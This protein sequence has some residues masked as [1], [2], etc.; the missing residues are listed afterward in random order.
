MIVLGSTT[1]TNSN[2]IASTM[3]VSGKKSSSSTKR[4]WKSKLKEYFDAKMKGGDVCIRYDLKAEGNG[5]IATVF[6]PEIGYI[7]GDVCLN[8]QD[9]EHNAAKKACK[10]LDLTM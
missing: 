6:C 10:K 2:P 5:Y 7:D 1:C 4:I 8:K 9:A 3:P